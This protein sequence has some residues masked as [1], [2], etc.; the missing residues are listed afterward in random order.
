M[1]EKSGDDDAALGSVRDSKNTMATRSGATHWRRGLTRRGRRLATLA[2]AGLTAVASIGAATWAWSQTPDEWIDPTYGVNGVAQLPGD[3]LGLADADIDNLGRALVVRE[4]GPDLTTL[5]R[6]TVDGVLDTAFGSTGS[7]TVAGFG[8]VLAASN[9]TVVQAAALPTTGSVTVTQFTSTGSP[10]LL[11]GPGGQATITVAAHP[12]MVMGI[13]ERV[14]SGVALA[15]LD[16]NQFPSVSYLVAL[17]SAGSLDPTWAPT[18]AVP[19]VLP[20]PGQVVLDLASDGPATLAATIP[21]DNAEA[22]HLIRFDGAGQPDP[23]FGDN[24]QVTVPATMSATAVTAL[25][26]GPYYLA[27]QSQS[28]DTM[29]V[30]R[31]LPTGAV[32]TTFGHDGVAQGP[33]SDC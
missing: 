2:I 32:D 33:A 21:A 18:A 17:T 5:S 14:S 25:P 22:Q 30:S 3:V 11:F 31:I 19:G 9:G 16:Q 7:V 29:A 23:S 26:G 27:G 24:G 8:P 20:L 6:L 28:F 10:D 4:S 13:A 1:S 15:L 12:L